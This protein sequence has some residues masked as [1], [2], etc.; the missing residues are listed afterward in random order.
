LSKA[1]TVAM[2]TTCDRD[3]FGTLEGDVVSSSRTLVASLAGVGTLT[4]DIGT[5]HNYEFTAELASKRWNADV[6]LKRWEGS[7]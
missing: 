2:F 6:G 7:L 5:R 4:A 3:G 1:V